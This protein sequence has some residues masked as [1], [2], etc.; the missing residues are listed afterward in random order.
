MIHDKQVLPM[1]DGG[2]ATAAR[3]IVEGHSRQ[4]L[5]QI[6][7]TCPDDVGTAIRARLARNARQLPRAD[8]W[9]V[10]ATPPC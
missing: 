4:Q 1:D 6:L 2:R 8:A 5:E 7:R 3:V 9:S 10:R